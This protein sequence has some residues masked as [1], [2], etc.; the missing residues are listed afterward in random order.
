MDTYFYLGNDNQQ[1]GPATPDEMIAQGVNSSVLVWKPGM[2][3]WEKAA[4]VPELMPLFLPPPP[5][6]SAVTASPQQ[7][8]QPAPTPT[9][10]PAPT[11]QPVPQQPAQQQSAPQHNGLSEAE[12]SPL[13][14]LANYFTGPIS[15]GGK[16]YIGEEEI[17]FKTNA[18]NIPVRRVMALKDITGYKRGF[19]NTLVI[20]GGGLS[21]RLAVWKKTAIIN[22]IEKRRQAWFTKRGMPVPPL[23]NY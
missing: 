19:L 9:P 6:P 20:Y 4:K 13:N 5:P 7:T 10:Q 17:L 21:W 12:N 1:H 11:P 3:G 22:D 8:I 14:Y 23:T 2:K 15:H 18:I 16:L